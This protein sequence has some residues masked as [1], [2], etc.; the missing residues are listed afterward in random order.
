MTK[1]SLLIAAGMATCAA[2]AFAGNGLPVNGKHFNL[3]IIG[4]ENC[5]LDDAILQDSGHV[6]HVALRNETVATKI[7]LTDSSLLPD[8]AKH[9][10][11]VLDS[12]GCDDGK[13]KF[14]LPAN[15]FYCTDVEGPGP[16]VNG[17]P[18]VDEAGDCAVWDGTQ[19]TY[20]ASVIQFETYQVFARELGTPG[21]S[22]TMN[23]CYSIP[24]DPTTTDTDESLTPYCSSEVLPLAR[25]AGS[26]KFTDVTRYLTTVL[27]DLDGD[28]RAERYPLFADDS[29]QYW[30]DYW[31]SGLR[32]VQ[33]RFYMVDAD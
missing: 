21:G 9:P 12:D 16:A 24:D 5:K 7:L 25:V 31:N 23:T 1:L 14:A 27:I 26:P 18:T 15:E 17:Q 13:A 33:L 32:L 10:F 30:W 6:I 3:N 4:K 28:G 29:Y 20:P 2:A 8:G 11:Q 22:A 19:W